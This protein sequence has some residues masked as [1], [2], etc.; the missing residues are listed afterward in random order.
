MVS[1]AYPESMPIATSTYIN[2]TRS[3]IASDFVNNYLR[4]AMPSVGYLPP[5]TRDLPPVGGIPDDLSS[6]A[7]WREL[8][9]RGRNVGAP[10]VE[11]EVVNRVFT[12]YSHTNI[13]D[14]NDFLCNHSQVCTRSP[15]NLTS[16][17][18][19]AKKL[20]RVRH[21]GSI[22]RVWVNSANKYFGGCIMR[23]F[24]PYLQ[25]ELC[26]KVYH[27]SP[28]LQLNGAL[29][30]E[31]ALHA[32]QTLRTLLIKMD[33]HR[34]F[35]NYM[36]ATTIGI[37]NVHAILENSRIDTHRPI[38]DCEDLVRQL[39]DARVRFRDHVSSVFTCVKKIA[40]GNNR[41]RVRF[42]LSDGAHATLTV[43][44]SGRG[45][46]SST[47]ANVRLLAILSWLCF[48]ELFPSAFYT[49]N[50]TVVR[51]DPVLSAVKT[52]PARPETK[53]ASSDSQDRSASDERAGVKSPTA[54][55]TLR[56][57]PPL[58]SADTPP[59]QRT[60]ASTRL[61]TLAEACDDK[62]S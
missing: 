58:I 12:C 6:L 5:T 1:R 27:D 32:F 60:P 56:G 21:N 59:E 16:L 24:C 10:V 31:D 54:S 46:M 4:V 36:A 2:I 50:A 13:L 52:Q 17:I 15:I 37:D 26:A 28:N 42:E 44:A 51:R 35:T 48:T 33:K 40:L 14:L 41:V 49:R 34:R 38:G 29:Q 7:C 3:L 57:P 25:K 47:H 8:C 22:I 43:C 39:E 11:C 20:M 62:S 61:A 9:A 55:L 18:W 23:F 45:F 53:A 30:R 19:R